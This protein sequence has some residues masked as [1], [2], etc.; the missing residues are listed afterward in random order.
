MADDLN[1]DNTKLDASSDFTSDA[2]SG[3]FD[4][5]NTTGQ[6]FGAGLQN[7]T[8]L[9][10]GVIAG[11]F[12]FIIGG[13]LLFSGSEEK[14]P[15]SVMRGGTA[16]EVNEPPATN[17]IS[18][19]MKS[20]VDE[21]NQE[22][23]EDAQANNDSFVPVPVGPPTD[24]GIEIPDEQA[25]KTDPLERWRALQEE[26]TREQSKQLDI[27]GQ[28]QG[29]T[30]PSPDEVRRQEAI[31]KLAE[32]ML[33]GMQSLTDK[34]EAFKLNNQNIADETYLKELKEDEAAELAA[35]GMPGTT[36]G[37][38][39]LA[40]NVSAV[41]PPPGVIVPEGEIEYAQTLIEANSD[42]PGPVLAQVVTGPLAGSRLIGSFE[43]SEEGYLVL[44]FKTAVV[45]RQSIPINAIAVDPDTN[46]TGVATEVNHRYFKRALLPAAAAFVE[47]F[48]DAISQSGRT[49][50]T[51]SGDSV[52]SVTDSEDLTNDQEVALGISEAGQE[53]S[54]FIEDEADKTKMMVRVAAGTPIG[55]LFLEPLLEGG[56]QNQA[57]YQ[58]NEQQQQMQQ[59]Q[60]QMQQFQMM[61]QLRQINN[62][63][64]SMPAY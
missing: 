55:I 43:T 35:N 29:T 31:G 28:N 62:A 4:D 2:G 50:V 46:L 61:Q 38:N 22:T 33:R 37:A 26:R 18:S 11:A 44:T 54:D 25:V 19:T 8:M 17:E 40:T 57:A 53:I 27:G 42:I 48:A 32:A 20:A 56:A 24:T 41:A 47:G 9:K 15:P 60:M 34:K 12:I 58:Q 64:N 14:V 45:D 39:G 23:L 63:A 21:Y 7:N 52:T 13:F 16:N 3:E 5:F 10:V 30:G 6:G 51:I 59:Q 36:A 49:T 1:K